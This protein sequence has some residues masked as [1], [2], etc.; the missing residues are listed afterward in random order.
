VHFE[1]SYG[2]K[3]GLQGI[4]VQTLAVIEK[5]TTDLENYR[6]NSRISRLRV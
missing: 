1:E 5:D 3:G 4:S 2:K 6:K